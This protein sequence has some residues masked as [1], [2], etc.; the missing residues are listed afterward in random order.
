MN[1]IFES[2]GNR[3]KGISF[4]PKFPWV[5]CS[6]YSGDILLWDYVH[7]MLIDT[8]VGHDGP[9]RS[10]DF[11]STQPMFVSGSDDKTIK[12]WNYESKKCQYT[13]TGHKD[14]V[15]TVQFHKEL[16]WIISCGD[17]MT[18][19]IWNWINRQILATATGHDHYVM[20]A[21]FHPSQDWIVSASLDST[22]R[23]W[24]YSVLRKKFFVAGF[25]QFNVITMDVTMIHK[26]E[27]HEKGV[28]WAIFHPSL[29]LIAS[30]SDD[31]RILIWK[32]SFSSWTEADSLRGHTNNVSCVMFHPKLDYI[33]SNSEDKTL[34]IWDLNKKSTIDKMTKEN[35]RFWILATHPT[36]PL[37][38]AGT[39]SEL[40]VFKLEDTRIPSASCLN[41]ILFYFNNSIKIWKEGITEKKNL[42]DVSFRSKSIKHGVVALL[43]NPFVKDSNNS[44][45][46]ILLINDNGKKQVIHYSS[47]SKNNQDQKNG[48]EYILDASSACYLAKNRLLV[49]EKE[50]DLYSY[51]TNNFNQKVQI[52]TGNIDKDQFGSIYQATLG[53]FFLKFKNGIV[54]LFDVNTRKILKETTEITEMKYVTWNSNL[55]YAALVGQTTIFIINKNMEI[56]TKIKE[57]SSIKSACFDENNVLFYTTYFH[58]KYA[59]IEPGLY[60]IVKSTETP[61][62]LMNVK[63]SVIYYSTANQ[64]IESQ[65]IVYTDVAFKLNLLNKNYENIVKMLKAGNVYGNKTVESIQNAGFPDLSM[66]FVVDPK[67]KFNLALK[68]GKLDEAKEAAE[69]LKE[70]VY[71]DKLA[72]KA[73]MMGK[74]DIAEFCYVKSQNID[75]LIFFY[76]ITGRQDKLKKVTLALK[77]TGDNSRRFLNAIYT[78]NNEEKI[79]VLKETGHSSLALLV[80]KLNNRN[81]LIDKI[82]EENKKSGKK[83][84]INENDFTEIKNNMGLLTP[85]K[86]IVNPKN[87][88]YHSNWSSVIE[89]K[90]V[91]QQASIDNILNQNQNEEEENDVFGQIVPSNDNE[92]ETNK[93]NDNK[94]EKEDKNKISDKWKDDE[95]EEDDEEI[96]K[97]LEEAKKKE[98]AN[99]ANLT[100][101]DDDIITRQSKSML[102]GIQVA[103]GNFKLALNYLRSQVGIRE[104]YESLRPIIKD[105]Y[106]SSYSQFKIMP[107]LAPI[108]FNLR[109]Q[110]SKTLGKLIPQNGVTMLKLK[111]MLNDGYTCISN[112]EMQEGMKIFRDVLKYVIF[113]VATNE[114]EE[115]EI[116]NIISICAEY[117]YLTKLS[118]LADEVK[119]KDKDKVKYCELYCL[120]SLCKLESD[121]HKFLIYK[122]AKYCCK[123]IKNFITA[124]FFIKKMSQFENTLG[125]S[126]KKEF[127]KIKEEIDLFQKIGTNKQTINFDTNENLPC[128]KD[129][130]SANELKRVGVNEKILTCPLCNSVEF[131]NYKGKICSTC[132]LST[133]G[134]EVIGFKVLEK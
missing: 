122:K 45:D 91:N 98:I 7:K 78:C 83:V 2:E 50:G 71:F 12:I 53:R 25:S 77:Q 134:E 72:E 94:N 128:I 108:E 68:S 120:M 115:K 82:N 55:T 103:L 46:F 47:N 89:V 41:N 112:F 44:F 130:Y 35:D 33:I 132:N 40:I 21:F 93:E 124:L 67:Q 19:R 13:L 85:L 84:K 58:V 101:R 102:P 22:I 57:K 14:Y 73:M 86:P 43:R 8:Y 52:L 37:F 26:L 81:D 18:I 64:S 125:N 39:D 27:G 76:T 105:I 28:N 96:Q 99:N 62:Y 80:A 32:Y 29:N 10:V 109:Q 75:K 131:M 61:L 6:Y 60:G 111:N 127:N 65:H 97:M 92:K 63:N 126:F 17:D 11:H 104:N 79:N 100:Q 113:F 36:I 114:E 118:L 34:R 106:L 20:S 110:N 133:L 90:K 87:K 117:I 59:L 1:V 42:C 88:E 9:V 107:Y 51:D 15:R 24:D 5:L 16:P 123:N 56:I 23:I 121:E 3:V 129:F 54:A 49:L 95:D 70:K 48:N 116:K 69:K 30:S 119:D 74:L 31:K 4:H 66:K 38:A